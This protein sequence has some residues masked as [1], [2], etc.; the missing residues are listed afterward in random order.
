LW[1]IEAEM[2][3][4]MGDEMVKLMGDEMV[5]LLGAGELTIGNKVN[6]TR[7]Q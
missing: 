4:L 1:D 7:Q 3:K 5:K 2:V 6:K